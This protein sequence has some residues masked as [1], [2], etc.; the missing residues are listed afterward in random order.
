M[1]TTARTLRTLL[2]PLAAAATAAT[3][4]FTAAASSMKA[5]AGPSP[6]AQGSLEWLGSLC[7]HS[8]VNTLDVDPKAAENAPNK[9]KRPVMS[10]HYV[11]VRPTAIADPYLVAYAENFACGELGLTKDAVAGDPRFA[12]V[13][14]GGE[15]GADAVALGFVP[16]ATPYALSIFG[17]PIP[18]PD[19][20]NGNGYGDGRA[21]SL[22]EVVVPATGK[23]WEFQLKGGGTT[24]F[25]RG[26]DG[27]AVLRSSVREF[28]AQEAMHALGISTTR[29]LSLV[30][31]RSE[32]V[33]RPWYRASL[34]PDTDDGAGGGGGGGDGGDDGGRRALMAAMGYGTE[35]D[36]MQREPCAVTTRV[37]PSFLRVGHVEL[38]ARRVRGVIACRDRARAKAQ[39]EKLVRHVVFREYSDEVDAS[40]PL[41]DQCLALLD[42][43]AARLA[44][45]AAGWLSVGY[46]QSNFNSDNCLVGGRTMDY[47]PFG[48][49][50]A[51]DRHWVMWTGGGRHFAFMN[52][53]QAAHANFVSFA[54]ALVPLLDEAGVA[55]A[56]AS[57]DR[58]RATAKAAVDETWR[59]KLGLADTDGRRAAAAALFD[60]DDGLEELLQD[61]G[62]DWT[63]FWRQLAEVP[64]AAAAA[65]AGGA[66][67]LV[68]V[69]DTALL[70][71]LAQA[72]YTAP[73]AAL[74]ARWAKWCRRWLAALAEDHGGGAGA[75]G[76]ETPDAA[77]AAAV[78]AA[79]HAVNPKYVPREWMLVRAYR[80]AHDGDFAELHELAELFAAPFDEQGAA[81]AAKYYRR[82]PACYVGR[83]GTAHMT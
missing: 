79:M 80:A 27:R 76:A 53:P 74:A 77:A 12:R 22:G 13:F 49:V 32:T 23:R 55:A 1:L 29:S 44:A 52:Q 71:P 62:P 47:G 6:P 8:Y 5:A 25:C 72:W 57:V 51:Y 39:L 31:S 45:L 10:G 30:A 16:F 40:L 56:Q 54:S 33:A 20:F 48:F 17:Q 7:D 28:L 59:K 67:K 68:D 35:P 38:H 50:E 15:D 42:A 19:P 4:S 64:A 83:G 65:V 82:T 18:A 66:T 26:A 41:Q 63:I 9:T 73:D 75:G 60:G 70:A 43:F 61:T 11:P 3:A 34:E 69:Q 2:R 24:P 58:F 36:M 21:V 14:G 78:K 37:A 46:V 81:R